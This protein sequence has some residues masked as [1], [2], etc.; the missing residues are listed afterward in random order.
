MKKTKT[1]RLSL[2]DKIRNV[3]AIQGLIFIGIKLLGYL[4]SLPFFERW[5]FRMIAKGWLSQWGFEWLV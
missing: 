3:L 4:S 2:I 1:K 5:A